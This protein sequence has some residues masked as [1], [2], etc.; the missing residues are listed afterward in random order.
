M[1][2]SVEKAS[3]RAA[4]LAD[5]FIT[6]SKGGWIAPQKL[7]LRDILKSTSERHPEVDPLLSDVS[8][9]ADLYPLY[10][11]DRQLS[12]VMFNLLK[13]AGEAMIEPK[14]VAIKG[15]NITLDNENSY[16][17]KEGDYLKISVI[18]NGRGIPPDHLQKIFDP[19]F[20]TKDKVTQ[21]GMGLGLAICY[22]VIKKQN[23]HIA[24]QSQVGTG[25]TVELYL[26]AF[27]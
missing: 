8:I 6:F 25:T 9:P 10:G 12:E 21:K 13:N 23:G 14:Q 17:L 16:S 5:K 19:Y 2:Q 7:H 3:Q 22:S 24:V 18:D 27:Q 15:E 26:P 11:D 20:S 1:V 4:G